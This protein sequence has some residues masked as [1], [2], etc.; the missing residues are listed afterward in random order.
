MIVQEVELRLDSAG[1][2][3]AEDEDRPGYAIGEF[4]RTPYTLHEVVVKPQFLQDL[5][6]DDWPLTASAVCPE[7]ILSVQYSVENFA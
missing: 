7:E 4:E 1:Q 5:L 6:R 2:A 3:G